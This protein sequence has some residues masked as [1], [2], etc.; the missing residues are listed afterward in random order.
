MDDYVKDWARA[1]SVGR[2]GSDHCDWMKDFGA[3]DV[4]CTFDVGRIGLNVKG[5]ARRRRPELRVHVRGRNGVRGQPRPAGPRPLP[6]PPRGLRV[7]AR[8]RDEAATRRPCA[9]HGRERARLPL[10]ALALFLNKLLYASDAA[11]GPS[12]GSASSRRRSRRRR[13]PG[14]WNSKPGKARRE[15]LATQKAA[16]DAARWAKL[17]AQCRAGDSETFWYD[18]KKRNCAHVAKRP[19]RRCV[20]VS[21]TTGEVASAAC[22]LACGRCGGR[23]LGFGNSSRRLGFGTSGRRLGRSFG[24]SSRHSGR[25]LGRS[26]YDGEAPDESWVMAEDV[27]RVSNHYIKMPAAVAVLRDPSVSSLFFVDLDAV[28]Q[29]PWEASDM[30]LKPK[31]ENDVRLRAPVVFGLTSHDSLAW[32]VHGSR[33]SL[34]G[35]Y[36]VD[37]MARWFENRCSFKDQYSLWQTIL[38]LAGDAGCVD[39]RGELWR[40]YGYWEA[41]HMSREKAHGQYLASMY[42]TC[43]SIADK[44]PDFGFGTTNCDR[45]GAKPR[46]ADKIAHHTIQEGD[47]DG[48]REFH[49]RSSSGHDVTFEV[50]NAIFLEGTGH[51]LT[52]T[53]LEHVT[54]ERYLEALG[55][56]GRDTRRHPWN[57]SGY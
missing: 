6:A 50:E 22:P 8:R 46:L 9:P 39:Y 5:A 21:Q 56:L 37:F 44:C 48:L 41:K 55:I 52:H 12:S 23:R 40:D 4:G 19:E 38:E 3:I 54:N 47:P 28:T 29:F 10:P 24:N 35:Q 25:R 18:K 27:T 7:R 43:D 31:D 34:R 17:S 42:V 1:G 49:Y 57:A 16:R 33:Y 11:C 30:A 15:K 45:F 13:R 32:Q 14:A 36:A 20:R 51:S 26:F 53:H 2:C